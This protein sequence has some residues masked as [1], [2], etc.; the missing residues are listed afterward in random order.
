MRFQKNF[1]K[2][3]FEYLEEE[4]LFKLKFQTLNHVPGD[5][6]RSEHMSFLDAPLFVH[7]K[8][9]IDYLLGSTSAY[10]STDTEETVKAIDLLI[11]LLL[12]EMRYGKK[13]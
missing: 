6:K 7:L 10:S 3:F 12:V 9:I 13:R 5:V 4:N 1:A 11:C 8:Y 2:L